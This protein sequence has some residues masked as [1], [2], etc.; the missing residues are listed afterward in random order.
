MRKESKQALKKRA[1]LHPF[2]ALPAVRINQSLYCLRVSGY[3]GKYKTLADYLRL[4]RFPVVAPTLPFD[5]S[6]RMFNDEPA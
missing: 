4:G 6:N 3:F 5:A 2:S 1:R